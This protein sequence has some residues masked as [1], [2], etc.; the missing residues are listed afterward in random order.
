MPKRDRSSSESSSS[1]GSSY[2]RKKRD[3]DEDKHDRK[4]RHRHQHRHHKSSKK[5]RHRGKGDKEKKKKHKTKKTERDR[6]GP[7]S[8]SALPDRVDAPPPAEISSSLPDR[9]D[10][11]LPAEGTISR[12][13]NVLGRQTTMGAMR[14]EEHAAQKAALQQVQRVYDPN[15]G[16]ERLVRLSGEIVEESVSRKEQQRRAHA[17]ARHVA[18]LG[19][20]RDPGPGSSSY[21]GRDKFPSQ[22]PWHGYK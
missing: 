6:S 19:P 2:E 4:H 22:H 14:P 8:S 3:R 12:M 20:A 11:P 17:K 18:V 5:H 10:A 16:V 15:L 21:T 13:E 9:V 7:S 1:S